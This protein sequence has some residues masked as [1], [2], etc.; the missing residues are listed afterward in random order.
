MTG[1]SRAAAACAGGPQR[2]G[3]SIPALAVAVARARLLVIFNVG[4]LSVRCERSDCEG[5][6]SD[7]ICHIRY[8]RCHLT[9][10]S[11]GAWSG[12]TGGITLMA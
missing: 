3:A 9:G 4:L 5:T 7:K 8:S 11:A 10:A 12:C 2:T 1:S 6:C